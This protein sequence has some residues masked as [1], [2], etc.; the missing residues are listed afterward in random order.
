MHLFYDWSSRFRGVVTEKDVYKDY[1]VFKAF[2]GLLYP[3]SF[4]QYIAMEVE[5]GNLERLNSKDVVD[6]HPLRRG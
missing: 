5:L 3:P 2:S 6:N 1:K 4:K